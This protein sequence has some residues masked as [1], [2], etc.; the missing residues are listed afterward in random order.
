LLQGS[1]S[2]GPLIAPLS[3]LRENNY[4]NNKNARNSNSSKNLLTFN[5]RKIERILANQ[6]R[7]LAENTKVTAIRP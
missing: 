7:R 1:N 6:A 5:T 3:S 2:N 4:N